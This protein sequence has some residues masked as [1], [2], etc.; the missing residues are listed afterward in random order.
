MLQFRGGQWRS[1]WIDD[2]ATPNQLLA[3]G[4]FQGDVGYLPEPIENASVEIWINTWIARADSLTL[5]NEVALDG[6]AT[7]ELKYL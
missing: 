5:T 2:Y 6:S 4:G 7:L 3:F 1:F